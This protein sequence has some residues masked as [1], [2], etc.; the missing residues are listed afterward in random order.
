VRDTTLPGRRWP[1]PDA[2]VSAGRAIRGGR[3]SQPPC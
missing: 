1:P 2:G 3:R